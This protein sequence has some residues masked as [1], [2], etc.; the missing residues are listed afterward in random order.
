MAFPTN[1]LL[2]AF[3]LGASIPLT[4]FGVKHQTPPPGRFCITKPS[5]HAMATEIWLQHQW[6]RDFPPRIA[7]LGINLVRLYWAHVCFELLRLETG[8]SSPAHGPP[9]L[10]M[11]PVQIEVVCFMR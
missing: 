1:E 2:A 9:S 10:A 4:S 3:G 8:L 11:G 6:A 7:G 5:P